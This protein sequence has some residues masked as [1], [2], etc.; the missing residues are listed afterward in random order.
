MSDTFFV[1]KDTR[2]TTVLNDIGFISIEKDIRPAM[3]PAMTL[4]ET[5]LRQNIIGNAKGYNLAKH[6]QKGVKSRAWTVTSHSKTLGFTTFLVAREWLYIFNG[7]TYK[8]GLRKTKRDYKTAPYTDRLGR[9]IG[10]RH[11]KGG[12]SRGSLPALDYLQETRNQLNGSLLF[13]S[14]RHAIEKAVNDK[15]RRAS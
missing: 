4:V 12:I 11:Y 13:S 6:A 9:K 8:S 2:P 15:I 10:E 14:L 5:R 7:G 3:K 1:E